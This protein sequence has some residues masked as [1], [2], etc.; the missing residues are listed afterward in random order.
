[1]I[2]VSQPRILSRDR[3]KALA[4]RLFALLPGSQVQVTI[5]SKASA[6][7]NFA[8]G[9]AHVAEQDEEVELTF[10]LVTKAGRASTITTSRIDETGLRAAAARAVAAAEQHRSPGKDPFMGPQTYP[11]AP[12]I[13]FDA[14]EQA[15]SAEPQAAIFHAATKAAGAERLISAGTIS[16]ELTAASIWNTRG[17]SAYVLGSFGEFSLT[18]R[19]ADGTGSGWGWSGYEDWAR[20][21]P[22]EVIARAVDLGRRSATPVAIEPGRY[23][24][25]MEPTATAALLTYLPRN[26]SAHSADLGYGPY[27]KDPLGTNKIGLQMIDSRL[28]ITSDPWDPERPL[29][30]VRTLPVRDWVPIRRAVTWFDNGVLTNLEYDEDYALKRGR[31]PVIDPRTLRLEAT[32]PTTTLEEMIASTERG[33]WVN[34]LS[35]VTLMSTKMLLL[36]GTTR[37]GAFLIEK[38]KITKPIK[39]LRFTDSP[40]YVLN[41]LE[42]VGPPVRASRDIVAP[43]IKARDFEFTSLTDA[44]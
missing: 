28:R 41:K 36:S 30:T 14:T 24:V 33:I 7:T 21:K 37:D 2:L 4:E 25:I 18:A 43:R 39:N 35:P 17:L 15:A 26:W 1:M 12:Q 13:Y 6:S 19:T 32:G 44:V 29:S 16:I 22:D 42:A 23:T 20:V 34:R 27:A 3:C 31:E 38:G 11:K 10:T 5:D 8:R 40:L 9:D